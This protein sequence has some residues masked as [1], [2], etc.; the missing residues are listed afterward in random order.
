MFVRN[1]TTYHV[2]ESN[3]DSESD[4]ESSIIESCCFCISRTLCSVVMRPLPFIPPSTQTKN[5]AC[6][7]GLSTFKIPCI[8]SCMDSMFTFIL[9]CIVSTMSKIAEIF[10]C[11]RSNPPR[12]PTILCFC[13]CDNYTSSPVTTLTFITDERMFQMPPPYLSL[14]SFSS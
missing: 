3:S 12:L 4:C 2:F 6:C 9:F 8:C 13:S 5:F 1:I 11:W 14:F 7:T 10:S